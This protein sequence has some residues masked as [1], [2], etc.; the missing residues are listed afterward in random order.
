MFQLTG[1]GGVYDSPTPGTLAGYS[2]SEIYGRLDCSSA[3]RAIARG[4]YVQHRVFFA[5]EATAL[6]VGYRPCAVC[7]PTAYAAWRAEKDRGPGAE[8]GGF[9]PQPPSS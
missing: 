8:R 7:L 2:R 4:G 6:E 9:G 3:L 5:D 1:P